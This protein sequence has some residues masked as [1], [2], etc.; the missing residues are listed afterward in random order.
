MTDGNARV[1]YAD[2]KSRADAG[3]F[4]LNTD[5]ELIGWGTDRYDQDVETG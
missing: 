4:L 5:G 1:L 3:T 2:V